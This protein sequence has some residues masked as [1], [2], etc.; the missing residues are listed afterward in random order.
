MR[1]KPKTTVGKTRALLYKRFIGIEQ[2]FHQL[3]QNIVYYV[4]YPTNGGSIVATQSWYFD[5]TSQQF[6]DVPSYIKPDQQIRVIVGAVYTSGQYYFI[7]RPPKE[8]QGVSYTWERSATLPDTAQ[9]LR[10]I[11]FANVGKYQTNKYYFAGSFDFMV[12]G[13]MEGTT[14][15][16]IK[17]NIAPLTS[18]NIVHYN[19]YVQLSPDDLV[20]IDGHLYSVENPDSTPKHQPK[21]YCV[22]HATL[23]S[24]L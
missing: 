11:G 18:F 24:I 8:G 13:S 21:D 12:K 10:G 7:L 22:Y 3:D 6:I 1:L 9:T 17:G 23:N 2:A 15:Q 16:Y 5:G 14:T 4:Q 20:V 19:D